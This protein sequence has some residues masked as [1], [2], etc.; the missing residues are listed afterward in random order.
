MRMHDSQGMASVNWKNKSP[1]ILLSTYALPLTCLESPKVMCL[2]EMVWTSPMHLE[3]TMYMR[4]A[5][6]ADQLKAS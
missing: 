2:G 1:M 6:V 3:Y 5:D 4:G